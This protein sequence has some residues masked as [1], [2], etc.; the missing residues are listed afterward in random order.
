MGKIK[1][2]GGGAQVVQYRTASGRT[3]SRLAYNQSEELE[4]NDSGDKLWLDFCFLTCGSPSSGPA[5]VLPG[6]LAQATAGLWKGI[7][8][9]VIRGDK[10]VYD[11]CTNS[12]PG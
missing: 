2:N 6:D 7:C 10:I 11:K 5:D 1:V 9:T 8:L 12:K 3:S 4:I